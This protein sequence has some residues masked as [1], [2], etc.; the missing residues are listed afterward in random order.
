MHVFWIIGGGKFGSRAGK[1]LTAKYPDA[2][3]TLVDSNPD[4][5]QSWEN[6]ISVVAGDAIAFLAR[7]LAEQNHPDWIVA[8]IP[9]H[10]MYEWLRLTM[11]RDFTPLPVPD[12]ISPGL[13]HPLK[14]RNGELYTS[15]AET[16]CPE[17]CPEPPDHCPVTGKPRPMALY[18]LLEKQSF[19]DF[20]SAV[21]RSRL[22]APGVGGCKAVDMLKLK[23]EIRRYRG[24]FLISTACPC[25]GVTHAAEIRTRN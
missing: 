3:I 11:G 1:L 18:R 2:H 24:R 19:A 10:I 14:G 9:I 25:Q 12:E 20:R 6:K 4:T 15:Y 21:L 23:N 17:D 7:H 5:L 8:A 13:P 22:L 16:I